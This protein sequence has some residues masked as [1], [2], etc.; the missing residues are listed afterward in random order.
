MELN[1]FTLF[2]RHCFNH[3]D[4]CRSPIIKLFVRSFRTLLVFMINSHIQ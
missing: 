2:C 4:C 1:H 3:C